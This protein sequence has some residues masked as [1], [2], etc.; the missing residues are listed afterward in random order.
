MKE[1]VKLIY[2]IHGKTIKEVLKMIVEKRDINEDDLLQIARIYKDEPVLD[3][4]L[5]EDNYV[6]DWFTSVSHSKFL[7]IL[8]ESAFSMDTP[9]SIQTEKKYP[10]K[11][12]DIDIKLKDIIDTKEKIY[13]LTTIG[14]E[15]AILWNN[16]GGG[17]K[18][19]EFASKK[20]NIDLLVYLL[21]STR[22]NLGDKART[23][24]EEVLQSYKE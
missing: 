12:I 6:V 10:E 9:I 15:Y 11:T 19:I 17:T 23:D 20:K 5:F 14:E 18:R 22:K 24:L 13:F 3:I 1:P 16:P 4:Y 21:N 2:E 8:K 7:T